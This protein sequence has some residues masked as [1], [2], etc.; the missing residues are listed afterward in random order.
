[1]KKKTNCATQ[2]VRSAHTP[3]GRVGQRGWGG[4]VGGHRPLVVDLHGLDGDGH[5]GGHPDD[6][7]N[8]KSARVDNKSVRVC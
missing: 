3:L 7:G 5:G 2:E 6:E 4:W 8:C 1:M